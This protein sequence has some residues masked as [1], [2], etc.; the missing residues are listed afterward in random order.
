ML[1]PKKVPMIQVG[2]NEPHYH[3]DSD[4]ELPHYGLDKHGPWYPVYVWRD[5]DNDPY[6]VTKAEVEFRDLVCTQYK[7]PL[8][9]AAVLWCRH[10]TKPVEVHGEVGATELGMHMGI[11][12][13][14]GIVAFVRPEDKHMI[15]AYVWLDSGR[16]VDGCFHL[17]GDGTFS[18]S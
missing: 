12:C 9:T 2:S 18:L 3:G 6:T 5:G 4:Q 17:F 13:D 8:S 7:I 10:Y 1:R 16:L 15:Y 14:H 11:V